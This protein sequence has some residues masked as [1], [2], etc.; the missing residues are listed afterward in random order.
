MSVLQCKYA[1]EASSGD[2][3]KALEAL[4]AKGADVALKKKD[5]TLGAGTVAAYVHTGDTIGSMVELF[6]ETDFVARNDE[7]KTLAYDIAMQ[8]AATDDDVVERGAE[9]ILEEPFIKDA[10]R[11]VGELVQEAVQ[12]FGERIEIGRITKFSI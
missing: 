9:A 8:I 12:K 2:I 1:L 5:R 4:R 6:C 3:D 11:I 10:G 7:F